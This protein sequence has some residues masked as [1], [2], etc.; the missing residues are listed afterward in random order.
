MTPTK[1]RKATTRAAAR[2]D[3]VIKG[4]KIGYA[5]ALSD[6]ARMEHISAVEIED[7]LEGAG[8]TLEDFRKVGVD[9]GDIAKLR[10]VIGK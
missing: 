8:L 9:A 4:I 6:L 2:N 3:N 10:E 7:A 5:L 1:G